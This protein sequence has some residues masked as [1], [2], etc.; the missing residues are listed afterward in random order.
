VAVRV[1][2][3]VKGLGPGGAERLLV[4]AARAHDPRSVELECAYV[5]P[6]KDHLAGALEGAG[7]RCTCLS[8]RPR[9]LT[10][11][12]ALRA[13]LV[14]GD[15][16]VVHVHS[17]VPGSV[18]RSLVRTLPPDRRPA[19]ISTE[20]NTWRRHRAPT[21][22]ANRATSRWDAATFAV[23]AETAASMS[24]ATAA[25]AR[26][27]LHGI[28]VA[29]V[30]QQ[31]TQREAVRAELG[32]GPDEDVVGTVANFTAQKA[33][34]TLLTAARLVADRGR[35]VRVVA[36]GQGPLEQQVRSLVGT[37]GLEHTVLLTGF[38]DDAVRV[39]SAFD[40]FT[41]ASDWEGLPVA[42]MEALALGLPVVATRVGGVAEELTDGVEAV[43]VPPGDPGALAAGWLGLLDDPARREALA[44]GSLRRAGD[45]DVRRSVVVLEATYSTLARAG[46]GKA[47]PPVAPRT[48]SPTD[49]GLSIR[50][51]SD[52]DRP[53]VLDLL[54][55]S[56]GADDPRYAQFF[57][58]KH[59]QNPFGPSP[60]WVA[61]EDGRV[62][63]FRTFLRWEF[64][65]GGEVLRAVRAVDTA[66]DPD[67]RG[68]GLFR[69]LT[70]HGLER[71][72]EEGVAC[73]FNTPNDKSRPGYLTMGWR[74][75]GR[76]AVAVRL[77]HPRVAVRALGSRTPAD[78]WSQPLQVGVDAATWLAK[79]PLPAPAAPAHI[80]VLQTHLTPAFLRWRY[81]M[82][83]LGYRVVA[84]GA[85]AVVV[86]ARRRG[87]A[88]ELAVVAGWGDADAS[89]R[90]AARALADSGADYALRLGP[91]GRRA[92]FTAVPGAG[93]RLTWR[94]LADHGMPPLPSWALTLGDVELF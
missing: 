58:W 60:M 55:R 68:R 67:Y 27:L 79:R 44:G 72:R 75:V 16:D 28:D 88:T 90:A 8:S 74:D 34:P 84:D 37:L 29:S 26:V 80:R 43:L 52:A 73:V 42:L 86:R 32:I 4:A 82:P 17:P 38:R 54:R 6:H 7:V 13:L 76:L 9:D 51:A 40:V 47:P 91:G 20:H 36:V 50:E 63:A 33:Y 78:R 65:R 46:R 92:R 3:V 1:L 64:V 11:P 70:L 25:R 83:L 81:G 94:A 56:L 31:R 15:F 45:F 59:D 41:L 23:S 10:W 93:P 39:M 14:A 87:D 30:A 22:W 61:E 62:V 49:D 48:A 53:A 89:D 35:P 71:L 19:L 12:A 2:W 77:R 21:R 5:L 85:A 18:A 57:A 66:T 24:G 69:A